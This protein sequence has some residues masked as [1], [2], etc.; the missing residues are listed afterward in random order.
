MK[1]RFLITLATLVV[2]AFAAQAVTV[3]EIIA[4]FPAQDGATAN[5]LFEQLL[6]LDDESGETYSRQFTDRDEFA[7]EE[8]CARIVPSGAGDDNAVRYALSG[9]ARYVSETIY[10]ERHPTTIGKE[11]FRTRVEEALV[12][13]LKKQDDPECRAFLLR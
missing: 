12:N 7:L 2:S 8:L 1:T 13:G 11:H 3:D 6:E 9:L 4:Q 10:Q 5:S